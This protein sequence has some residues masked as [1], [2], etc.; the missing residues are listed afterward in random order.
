VAWS[1]SFRCI[2]PAGE[3]RSY[4]VGHRDVDEFLEFIGARARPNTVRAYAHDLA[5]FF[6]VVGKEP[7]EVSPAD[8]M[9]FVSAQ[10][11][12]RAGAE[13]VVRLADGGAGLAAST[14]RRRL[15][16]VSSLYGYLVARGDRGVTA[17]P[18]PRGL[19][20]RLARRAGSRGPLVPGVRQLPRIL[21]MGEVEALL[22]AL[23]TER[24]RAIV[25]A[26]VL[27]G[28]RRCEVLGLRLGDLRLGEWRVFI[29]EGK[30]GHQRIVPMSRTFFDVAA[31]YLNTE[32]P[33]DADTDHVFIALKGPTRG[34]PLSA[35]GLDC[36]FE[37][38]CERCGFF[39]TGPEFIPILRRQRDHAGER[40]QHDRAALFDD[41][42]TAIPDH[43]TGGSFT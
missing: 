11:R 16:A 7:A 32:R 41:I 26:M 43:D 19:P 30:G 35:D 5:V 1:P 2:V 23:R 13:K 6:V 36:N 25:L 20:T 29:A 10:Q 18:V 21:E 34:W 27:G 8:V 24:D 42:I 37:S 28:L 38:I 22:A 3:A 31:R 40:G 39:D 12:P 9:A 4:R 15:A 17:N 33:P 14:I